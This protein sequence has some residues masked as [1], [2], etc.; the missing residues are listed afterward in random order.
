MCIT[1][2]TTYGKLKQARVPLDTDKIGRSSGANGFLCPPMISENK[3]SGSLHQ[4]VVVALSGV[5][6]TDM[7]GWIAENNIA[8]WRSLQ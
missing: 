5:R 4:Y 7:L 6:T 2:S 8:Y 3:P 1:P